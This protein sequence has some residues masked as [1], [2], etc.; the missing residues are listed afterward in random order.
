MR[1]HY[2][3]CGMDRQSGWLKWY[4]WVRYEQCDQIWPNF[5][6]FTKISKKWLFFPGLIYNLAKTF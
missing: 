6:T 5:A 1:F 4:T 2:W 3:K